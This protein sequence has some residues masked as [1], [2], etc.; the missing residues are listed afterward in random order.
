MHYGRERYQLALRK[1]G[2][3]CWIRKE[4]LAVL[5]ESVQVPTGFTCA[6]SEKMARTGCEAKW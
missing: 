1:G 4:K 5:P 3:L 2:L 6:D